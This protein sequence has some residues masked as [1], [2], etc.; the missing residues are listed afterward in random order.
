MTEVT[1]VIDGGKECN[2]RLK[3]ILMPEIARV[4]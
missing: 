2:Q 4:Y 1:E 3:L